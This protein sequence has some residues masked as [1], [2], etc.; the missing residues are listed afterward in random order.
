MILILLVY[1][2]NQFKFKWPQLLHSL[3][4]GLLWLVQYLFDK[5]HK[6]NNLRSPL[7]RY[8]Q[9]WSIAQPLWIANQ[10]AN[11]L[12]SMSRPKSSLLSNH[13]KIKISSHYC[14]S[15]L[16]RYN[17]HWSI[18]QPLW[19]A[20]QSANSL[21]SM[22]RPKSSLLSNHHKIKISSHCCRS[23]LTQLYLLI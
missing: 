11:S 22:S 12:L 19:I 21:L 4:L 17:Q 2:R 23:P 10:S 16:I 7:I 6:K 18:A 8:N 14:R 1:L 9:Q 5:M 13:H 20:N 15:P 3:S